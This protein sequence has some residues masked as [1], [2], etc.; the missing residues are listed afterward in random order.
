MMTKKPLCFVTVVTG[1]YAYY[2][3]FFLLFQRDQYP[4]YDTYIYYRGRLPATV[5]SIIDEFG[6]TGCV[7]ESYLLQFND[8]PE[9]IMALRWLLN[10]PWFS[11]YESLF[12]SDIDLFPFR[13]D[14]PLYERLRELCIKNSAPYYNTI[15]VDNKERMTGV[16]FI[17]TDAYF[18]QASMVLDHSRNLLRL[19][20]IDHVP[21]SF[22]QAR[23]CYDNQAALLGVIGAAGLPVIT[24]GADWDYHGLHLGHSKIPGRWEQMFATDRRTIYWWDAFKSYVD[25]YIFKYLLKHTSGRVRDEF[26]ALIKEGTRYDL[27]RRSVS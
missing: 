11:G 2:I 1:D 7:D 9:T 20:G 4:Q 18:D 12:I 13:E 24:D 26:N 22:N 8:S 21:G 27:H 25:D 23:G 5:R 17:L 3:P 15:G 6:F 10:F 16:H 14:P 19:H